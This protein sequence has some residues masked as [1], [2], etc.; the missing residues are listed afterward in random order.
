MLICINKTVCK[1]FRHC[2]ITFSAVPDCQPTTRYQLLVHKWDR[3]PDLTPAI[4]VYPFVMCVWRHVKQLQFPGHYPLK[5]PVEEKMLWLCLLIHTH[6]ISAYKSQQSCYI[7]SHVSLYL[8]F[9]T[10]HASIMPSSS[11]LLLSGVVNRLSRGFGLVHASAQTEWINGEETSWHE[12]SKH[13][14]P[15]SDSMNT[16]HPRLASTRLAAE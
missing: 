9:P 15:P 10:T 6:L 3:Q 4:P 16:S 12:S 7:Y 13:L 2:S 1:Q 8:L 5:R 11:V 14:F